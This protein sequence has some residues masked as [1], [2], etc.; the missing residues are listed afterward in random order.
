MAR[1]TDGLAAKPHPGP[2]PRLS[3]ERHV[4]LEELPRKGA[5]AHGWPNEL[6]TCARIRIL[7]ERHF[8]IL[9]HHDHVGRLLRERLNWT[10]QKPQRRAREQD[11]TEVEFFKRVKEYSPTGLVAVAVV[12]KFP[13]TIALPS[14]VSSAVAWGQ[15]RG[16][17]R[18]RARRTDRAT[19]WCEMV[20]GGRAA[21]REAP[22]SQ[23]GAWPRDLTVRDNSSLGSGFISS[24]LS[25]AARDVS[26]TSRASLFAQGL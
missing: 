15:N 24:G 18:A 6:W 8:G 9:F 17:A 12:P 25:T 7:I 11:K 21:Q 26:I 1:Q 10:P 23:V 20:Q 5:K 13:V 16:V 3:P 4:R 2:P 22:R 19:A 14:P